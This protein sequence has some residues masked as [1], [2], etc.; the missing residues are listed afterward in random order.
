MRVSNE[1]HDL[2]P[3]VVKVGDNTIPR[4]NSDFDSTI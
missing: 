1:K 2:K 3:Q 4:P